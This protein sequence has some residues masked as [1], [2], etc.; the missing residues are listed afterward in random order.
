MRR[1]SVKTMNSETLRQPFLF[2]RRFLEM[3]GAVIEAIPE[4]FDAL[5]P[6]DLAESL[7][8]PDYVRI[9]EGRPSEGEEGYAI[10]YGSLLLDKMVELSCRHLPLA[11]CQLSF[12]YLKS[13]GFDRLIQDQL[14]F[15]KSLCRVTSTAAIKTDYLVL[16]C[17]YVAR[18][19]E[20]KEGLISFAFHFDTGT[21]VPLRLDMSASAAAE[22]APLPDSLKDNDKWNR[23]INT[24]S[25]VSPG[26]IAHEIQDFRDSM[27]RRLG[28]D[29]KNLEE[30]YGTLKKEMEESLGRSGLSDHLV[31]DR[32]QKIALLPEELARKKDD[33]IEKYS[34]RVKV[35]PCAA[36][37]IRTPAVRVLCDAHIG[38]E[39]RSISLTYNPLTKAVDPLLCEGCG[40]SCK[41][42]SFCSRHHVLCPYCLE[43]C[44]ACGSP[45]PV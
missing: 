21:F 11:S 6:Q 38:R 28:R 34:I 12:H 29:A 1:S 39:R 20:Q 25:R 3:Q 42:I 24:L 23:I 33:L 30:Y 35:L 13:Q 5:L 26:L 44:P 15:R 19:D 36:L 17:R 4:G 32:K 2:G 40:S 10:N 37:F 31:Q 27:N 16:T 8:I 14:T 43:N 9:K 41:T 22:T 45:R 7:E 18:S